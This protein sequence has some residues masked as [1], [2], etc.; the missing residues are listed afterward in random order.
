MTAEKR[1]NQEIENHNRD[2]NYNSLLDFSMQDRR[3]IVEFAE[4]LAKE[5][6]V[7]FGHAQYHEDE[8]IEIK[9]VEKWYDNFLAKKRKEGAE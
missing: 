7:E 3:F 9:E 2:E 4:S 5:R 8:Q 6:A 1:L